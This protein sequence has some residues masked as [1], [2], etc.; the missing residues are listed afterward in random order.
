MLPKAKST[1]FSQPSLLGA[2][3][4][5][6][7]P[8]AAPHWLVWTPISTSCLTPNHQYPTGEGAAKST[9]RMRAWPWLNVGGQPCRDT[10]RS[11]SSNVQDKVGPQLSSGRST[12][13]AFPCFKCTRQR[14]LRSAGNIED[15]AFHSISLNVSFAN[16]TSSLF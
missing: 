2:S 13:A 3:G 4:K 8:I 6:D 16:I 14:T 5:P 12:T 1:T 7:Y 9:L 10:L 11:Q 15:S